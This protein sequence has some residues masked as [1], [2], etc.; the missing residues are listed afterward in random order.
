M[1]IPFPFTRR[2]PA[3]PSPPPPQALY[4]LETTNQELKSDLK[5]LYIASAKEIDI[6]SGRKAIL[7]EVSSKAAAGTLGGGG[8][9]PRPPGETKQATLEGE[10]GGGGLMYTWGGSEFV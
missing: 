5:D 10:A 7:I 1:G 4:D 6:S 2:P 9:S 8:A 3:R